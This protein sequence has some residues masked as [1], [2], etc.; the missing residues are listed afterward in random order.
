M[1]KNSINIVKTWHIPLL[2]HWTFHT[3]KQKRKKEFHFLKANLAKG[4][5]S[6]ILYS[7]PGRE[8][9]YSQAGLSC[10]TK[11]EWFQSSTIAF[12]S[13]GCHSYSLARAA[14][15]VR[16]GLYKKLIYHR[17]K[18]FSLNKHAE[19]DGHLFDTTG[20][21]E[22]LC[23]KIKRW[24]ILEKTSAGKKRLWFLSQSLGEKV[25][26]TWNGIEFNFW[27]YCLRT[28]ELRSSPCG[29][30]AMNSASILEDAGSIPGL[31]L[32]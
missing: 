2:N 30:A 7:L 26:F 20:G 25:Q 27:L 16:T 3:W 14:R 29:S 11:K 32:C 12:S 9:W 22:N 31:T 4:F 17:K 13:Q 23:W 5:L 1:G 8:E 6:F 21:E 24:W 28:W 10:K 18:T 15:A 19:S